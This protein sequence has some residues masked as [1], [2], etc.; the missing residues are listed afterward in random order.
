M[1]SP[2]EKL[3]QAVAS[4]QLTMDDLN[5]EGVRTLQNYVRN[6]SKQPKPAQPYRVAKIPLVNNKP[7][8][9]AA[10]PMQQGPKPS[11][12]SVEA[13]QQR[14]NIIKNLQ[15]NNHPYVAKALSGWDWV[16]KNTVESPTISRISQTGADIISGWDTPASDKASTGSRVGD[17][18]AD[19]AGNV[20]GFFANPT[21][22][23][24]VNVGAGTWD[25]GS[26]A[27]KTVMDKVVPNAPKLLK[28]TAEV[29]GGTV[30]YEVTRS[31]TNDRPVSGEETAKAVAGNILLNLLLHGTGNALGKGKEA[32]SNMFNKS[33]SVS[34]PSIGEL[35][36]QQT[37]TTN[38][39]ESSKPNMLEQ[40]KI[41]RSETPQK[42]SVKQTQMNDE[43]AMSI[44]DWPTKGQT[45]PGGQK[46]RKTV[47]SS[48]EGNRLPD[49]M[50]A[51]I[52]EEG[53]GPKSKNVYEPISSQQS[54]Q[55]ADDFINTK[56]IANAT[57][58]VFDTSTPVSGMKTELAGKL[59]DHYNN[60]NQGDMANAVFW[61]TAEELTRAGQFIERAKL[62]SKLT[63][64]GAQMA[65][66]KIKQKL[67]DQVVEDTP[68]LAQEHEQKTTEV[69]QQL[70]QANQEVANDIA[71]EIES[72]ASP[73]VEKVKKARA[74]KP[75]NAT[76]QTSQPTQPTGNTTKKQTKKPIDNTEQDTPYPD[77]IFNVASKRLANKIIDATK[78]KDKAASDSVNAAINTLFRVA[79]E[80]LPKSEQANLKK[81]MDIITN[82]IQKRELL[83]GVWDNSKNIVKD[84]LKK[85]PELYAALEKYFTEDI[86]NMYTEG[87][88]KSGV[89]GVMR[90]EKIDLGKL[91][92]QHATNV[93]NIRTNLA[94]KIAEELGLPEQE[95]SAIA[96]EVERK[97]NE[98]ATARKQTI[99]KQIFGEKKSKTVKTTDQR[100]IE[101]SNLGA[102]DSAVYRQ[103]VAEKLGLPSLSAEE[104]KTLRSLADTIQN[105]EGR[106]KDVAIGKLESELKK[107][108]PPSIGRKLGTAQTLGML[109]YPKTALRNIGGNATL[110]TLSNV[111]DVVGTL[112]D[113]LTSK[114]TGQRTT[115]LPS[116]PITQIKRT[117]PGVSNTLEDISMGIDTWKHGENRFGT[118]SGPA[119]ESGIGN[120]LETALR[121]E[122]EVPDRFFSELRE[123]ET[124]NQLMKLN[125][126]ETPTEEMINIAKED[127][128]KAILEDHNMISGFTTGL[129]KLMNDPVY[130]GGR[131]IG[132]TVD[133]DPYEFGL[134]D[135]I[136]K[137]PKVPGNIIKRSIEYSP[138][139]FFNALRY[140]ARLFREIKAGV[141]SLSTQK[142]FI[143]SLSTSVVG[144]GVIGLGYFLSQYGLMSGKPPTDL[145]VQKVQKDAG[146]SGYQVNLTAMQRFMDS[147]SKSGS[148]NKQTNQKGDLLV[149]YDWLQPNAIGLAIGADMQV[150]PDATEG[151]WTMLDALATGYNALA[152]QSVFQGMRTFFGG[153]KGEEDKQLLKI[154]A[155]LPASFIP[156]FVNGMNKLLDNT[157]RETYTDSP[158]ILNQIGNKMQAKIPGLASDL[159]PKY[160]PFGQPQE[161]YQNGS[162]NIWNVGF[163]PWF[164]TRYNPTP[165]NQMVMDAYNQTGETS[166]AP[167]VPKYITVQGKRINLS[168]EEYSK[169]QQKFGELLVGGYRELALEPGLSIEEKIKL[170][171][172]VRE[173]AMQ[174]AKVEI[175]QSRGL[176]AGPYR[177]G[178]WVNPDQLQNLP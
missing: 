88:L 63:P 69:K 112:P 39:K 162:N 49:S 102:L 170:M 91:V 123:Q 46:V 178:I 115:G 161:T 129:K 94:K 154:A 173:D 89:Q 61:Q 73:L 93:D 158:N 31:V 55:Q 105:S 58:H 166:P 50:K 164:A 2:E 6:K 70:E 87:Q 51:N 108:V 54:A 68:G 157:T 107:M 176:E 140:G 150:K 30:P 32:L 74:K 96:A 114:F 121:H 56:G 130:Y 82:Q 42:Y 13:Q 172:S 38:I 72:G 16:L 99:L 29:V 133:R 44:G 138:V 52:L 4:G 124:L 17:V 86:T 14:Q 143:N 26:K 122:L 175:L 62:F 67:Y 41:K 48:L 78:G 11:T 119:F 97:F 45:Y 147:V 19:V 71:T 101:Y 117:A 113:I 77:S 165:E 9:K 92:R 163:S 8:T 100:I 160:G 12:A 139:E 116:N 174:Q 3:Y 134:G 148:F 75:T 53:F 142:A 128:S 177:G 171:A 21:Q 22:G 43:S 167:S 135:F 118:G 120:K 151:V 155:S 60:T 156:S 24:S 37:K 47:V 36:I 34:E 125:K 152:E 103:L 20:G 90:D 1:P 131:L 23:G 66:T 25:V 98:L 27:V 141:P 95:S 153:K 65:G 59:I 146:V 80:K 76:E 104:A 5:D 33:E 168:G 85:N 169:L 7:R 64:D 109:L 136:I 110:N 83:R 137:F 159:P 149:T 126:V 127:A 40:M 79:K 144:T 57:A 145:D 28:S 81:P 18:A 84:K 111:R 35:P 15:K 10:L 106:A 132:K